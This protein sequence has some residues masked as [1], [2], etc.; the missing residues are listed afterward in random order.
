M[1]NIYANPIPMSKTA[2]P[3]PIPAWDATNIAM[4]VATTA[5]PQNRPKKSCLEAM[6]KAPIKH[7]IIEAKL[8]GDRTPYQVARINAP[9]TISVRATNIPSLNINPTS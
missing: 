2:I 9:I 6:M 7:S 4:P 5:P 8:T 3:G 1:T